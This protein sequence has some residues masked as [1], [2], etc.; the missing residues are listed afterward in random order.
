MSL[1]AAYERLAGTLVGEVRRAEPMMRHT[2]FRIGGPAD[3]FVVCDTVEDLT[4]TLDI[5]AEE[6]IQ[7]T[8]IGKG[9]NLLVSD[10]GYRGAVLV[11][12]RDFR[13]HSVDGD[14]LRAGAAVALAALVQEAFKRGLEG[15]AFAVGIPGTLGGA[16][17]G[18]AGAHGAWIGDIVDSVTLF[19]PTS[20]LERFR[21]SE[22][23]WGYRKSGLPAEGIIVE[24]TLRVSEGEPS[25]IRAEMERNFTA[26]K[27]TQPVGMPT[28]GS[29]FVNPE[30]D[31]AGRLIEVAGLKGCRV[32]G[33][34]VSS[35]HS[36]FIENACGATAEDV[37]NLMRKIQ[38]TVRDIHGVELKPE[39]RLLG[40]FS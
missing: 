30:G 7:W 18:N 3:L 25:R 16:L 19:M 13:K 12:G 22:V 27:E 2:S 24:G 11:L 8:V 10:D 6:E 37:R 21:G 36:N 40:T 4:H 9:T 31:A 23:L 29:V 15:L 14:K 38:M 5:L 35:V 26:R 17:A 1:D 39:I 34:R 20:G 28:A 33:A 32:G